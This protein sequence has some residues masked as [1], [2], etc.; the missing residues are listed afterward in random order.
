MTYSL[1]LLLVDVENEGYNSFDYEVL[2]DKQENTK[3]T[4]CGVNIFK[5]I[6]KI[7]NFNIKSLSIG[8]RLNYHETE[9]Q[10]L[11]KKYTRIFRKMRNDIK[12][13]ECS[14]C[15]YTSFH[16]LGITFN[17]EGVCSG[18]QVHMKKLFGLVI[19]A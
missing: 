4:I 19:K 5:A 3:I 18:C 13:I 15:L 11:K 16:P 12:Y 2:K 17:E 1:Q 8:N 14:K 10:N 9:I 6:P 7:K